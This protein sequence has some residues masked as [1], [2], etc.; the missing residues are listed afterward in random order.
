MKLSQSPLPSCCSAISQCYSS[1]NI[2]IYLYIR[3]MCTFQG[4]NSNSFNT[5]NWKKLLCWLLTFSFLC[6][7]F[8]DFL[9]LGSLSYWVSPL[10]FNFYFPYFFY[11]LEDFFFQVFYFCYCISDFSEL[12]FSPKYVFCQ[13]VV[14][15]SY[16]MN[17]IGSVIFLKIFTV[18]CEEMFFL[19]ALHVSPKKVTFFLLFALICVSFEFPQ[20][21]GDPY[22]SAYSF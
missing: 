20:M 18:F 22:L 6:S 9:L 5:G 1:M 21:S 11:F 7:L 8:L 3:I 12:L 15:C 14:S 2:Y 19:P 16:F 4:K 17:V 13:R 10:F